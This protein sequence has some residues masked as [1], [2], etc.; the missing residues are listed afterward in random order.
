MSVAHH[1]VLVSISDTTT[2][3]L[4]FLVVVNLVDL[5][6]SIFVEL[7]LAVALVTLCGMATA[8]PLLLQAVKLSDDLKRGD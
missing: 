4:G 2:A 3:T 8:V 7:I 1:A 5:V 6:L